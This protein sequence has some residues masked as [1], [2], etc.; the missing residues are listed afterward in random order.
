[1]SPE[2]EQVTVISYPHFSKKEI[3]HYIDKGL[4]E[5]YL[6]PNQILRMASNIRNFAD[7]KRKVFGLRS[8]FDYFSK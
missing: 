7:I 5:F 4:K 3:D 1:V 6:R 8:F 2:G